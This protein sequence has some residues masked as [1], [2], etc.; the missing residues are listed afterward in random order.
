MSLVAG[1]KRPSS[2]CNKG[3]VEVRCLTSFLSN[4]LKLHRCVCHTVD[5][6]SW[7]QARDRNNTACLPPGSEQ[8]KKGTFVVWYVCSE[9]MEGRK[10]VEEGR[11]ES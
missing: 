2:G 5:E 8:T 4:A 1:R 7:E 6:R 3:T 9:S 10:S 11:E